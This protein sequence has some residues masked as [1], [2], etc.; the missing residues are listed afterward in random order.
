MEFLVS[1]IENKKTKKRK[2]LNKSPILLFSLNDPAKI[3]RITQRKIK[4]GVVGRIYICPLP[5]LKGAD[6]ALLFI[7]F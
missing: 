7:F 3:T 1:F 6:L 4:P 5:V 2:K